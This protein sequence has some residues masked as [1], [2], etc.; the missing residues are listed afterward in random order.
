MRQ[1][2]PQWPRKISNDTRFSAISKVGWEIYATIRV[3]PK[4]NSRK[5]ARKRANC[6][7]VTNLCKF[8][9]VRRLSRKITV[10]RSPI[11]PPLSI[12]VFQTRRLL[13]P[14][15]IYLYLCVSTFTAAIKPNE[16]IDRRTD[17]SFRPKS[18][19]ITR[20]VPIIPYFLYQDPRSDRG[21]VD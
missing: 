7:E 20:F 6:Y 4:F 14:H 1:W 19:S 13:S 21:I 12:T 16:A 17:L 5:T 2:Y 11:Q 15:Y 3:R 10:P 9:Q 8:S 18:S